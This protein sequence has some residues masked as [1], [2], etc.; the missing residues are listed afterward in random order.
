MK[1]PKPALL[2][3]LLFSGMFETVTQRF[4]Q[5]KEAVKIRALMKRLNE[6]CRE[7]NDLVEVM[8]TDT[9]GCVIFARQ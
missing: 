3:L 6:P 4:L 5:I 1:I 2:F 7:A 8:D 9:R